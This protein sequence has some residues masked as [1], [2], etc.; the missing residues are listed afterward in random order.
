VRHV[1]PKMP[2]APG[3]LRRAVKKKK[4]VAKLRSTGAGRKGGKNTEGTLANKKETD[5]HYDAEGRLGKRRD[6]KVSKKKERGVG[7][8]REEKDMGERQERRN[9]NATEFCSHRAERGRQSWKR[10][11]IHPM[12]EQRKSEDW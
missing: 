10:L 7:K 11:G 5:R 6:E 12:K 3:D 4:Q 2:R 9:T 1:I 8:K